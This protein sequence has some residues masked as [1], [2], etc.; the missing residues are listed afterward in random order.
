[1]LA[2]IS[3]L[4][5]TLAPARAD[6]ERKATL[7]CEGNQLKICLYIW[8]ALPDLPG[9]NRDE[10][11][12][13]RY[14]A[15][16]MVPVDGQAGSDDIVFVGNAVAEEGYKTDHPGLSALDSFIADDNDNTRKDVPQAEIAETDPAITADGVRL[17]VFIIHKLKDGH[18]QIVAYTE[19]GDKDGKFFCALT[20][21]SKSGKPVE[22]Y[23]SLFRTWIGK[24]KHWKAN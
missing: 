13:Y 7:S 20:L 2:I 17:R 12:S 4:A 9:W 5:L 19:D 3:I 11:L 10:E 8:P 14:N 22:N 24:Y 21:D 16:F 6:I 1:M 18:S 23:L 15:A